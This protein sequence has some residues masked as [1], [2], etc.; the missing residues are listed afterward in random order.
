[1]YCIAPDDDHESVDLLKQYGVVVITTENKTLLQ[2]YFF[3]NFSL[4]RL[5]LK[6]KFRLTVSCHFL[7][8]FILSIPSIFFARKSVCFIEGVGSFFTRNKGFL[9]VLKLLLM[10]F[11][12]K[13]IFMNEYEKS[14]L[15]HK[16]DLVLG[17]I[18]VDI[19]S[20]SPYP[21]KKNNSKKI[22]LLY[23]GRLVED[24][25]IFYI[26]ELVRCLK[27]RGIDFILNVVGDTYPANPSSL[28]EN[29]I[30]NLKI[31]FEK[32]IFFHGYLC[33]LRNIYAE[34]DVLLLLSKH[35]GF[36]VVVMEANACGVPAICYS[37]P[38]C[39]DAIETGINGFL[40]DEGEIDGIV[41]LISTQDFSL[42]A[43]QCR[44]YAENNF[45]QV[46]K[47]RAII[48]AIESL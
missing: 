10:M 46:N 26:I 47:N 34:T 33:D 5:L 37:V 16:D 4:L 9:S 36:P 15:G 40:F 13:R 11:V 35:E 1:M 31:E 41:K 45:N 22:K 3:I 20:F 17:G 14:L 48:E 32:E 19:N 2:N 18:G 42:L 29:D 38:G 6:E 21:K 8:T 28:T 12:N 7:V 24:K 43:T 39:V 30:A 27:T 23:V 44:S 25:G